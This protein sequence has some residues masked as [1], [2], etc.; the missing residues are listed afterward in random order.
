MVKLQFTWLGPPGI[1]LDGRP[2]RLEMRKTL[3][4]LAYLSLSP[5]PPTRESLSTLFWPE[6]DQKHALSNLRRNLSSLVASLPPN[7]LTID[8]DRLGLL[9]NNGLN[10]DV[11]Q[12]RNLLAQR[13]QHGHPP[14]EICTQCVP[15]LEKAFEIYR[16]DFFEG[17]NLKDCPEF[18][19]WQ[20][21]TRE[22]L[23]EDF[24]EVLERLSLYY[25]NNGTWDKAISYTR[26]RLTLDRLNEPAQRM[27]IEQY[28]LSGQKN[29]ALR[30]F[31]EYKQFLDQELGQTPEPELLKLVEEIKKAEPPPTKRD[32][33]PLAMR[34]SAGV[35][36]MTLTMT[37][38]YQPKVPRTIFHRQRLVDQLNKSIDLP[39]TL[40]SA[41]AGFGKTTLL[42]EWIS[43]SKKSIAWISLDSGDN[44]QSLLLSYIVNAIRNTYPGTQIGSMAVNLLASSQPV[45]SAMILG[46]LINDLSSIDDQLVLV[47]DDYHNIESPAAHEVFNFLIDHLPENVHLVIST[48]SD[49]PL[50]LARLKANLQLGIIRTDDLRF[51]KEE[52]REFLTHIFGFQI[53]EFDLDFFE[54][55]VEGWIAG[56]QLALL[57]MR[58]GNP[59]EL[60]EFIGAFKGG[61]RDILDYLMQEVLDR[62]PE[63]IRRF[64]LHTSILEKLTCSLCECLRGEDQSEEHSSAD[65]VA[66]A[67]WKSCQQILEYLER[68]NI[69]LIPLDDE[70]KWFRYHH[71][72][73][74][75]LHL[76]LKQYEP[77]QDAILHKRAADWYAKNSYTL[78]AI[79][80][81]LDSGDFSYAADLIEEYS[82]KLIWL[83]KI[84]ITLDWFKRLPL[85]V[86]ESHPLLSIYQGF[87][88]ARQ[89]EF[90][91]VDSI[92][93]NIEHY[94]APLPDSPKI[95]EYRI[96]SLGMRAFIANLRGEPEKSIQIFEDITPLIQ[97]K[98]AASYFVTRAQ[99]AVAYLDNGNL[100]SAEL[101][102]SEMVERAKENQDI[103]FTI[104]TNKE[105]AE[106]YNIQ[107][108]PGRA[109]Q[110]Y[111]QMYEWLQQNIHDPNLYSG[112]LKVYQARQLIEKNELETASLLL[113]EEMETML[114]VWQSSALYMGYV[115]LSDFLTC[116][117]DYKR[118]DEMIKKALQHVG[119][120]SM[121]PRNRS[122]VQASQVNLWLAEDNLEEA[123]NWALSTFPQMPTEFPFLKESDHICLARIW[124]KGQQWEDAL[125]LL[126]HL[127][128]A[129]E[130][131]KRFGRLLK[132]NILQS[133]ALHALGRSS[134]A[135]D[136]LENCIQFASREN[137]M[138]V[139]L[140]EGNPMRILLLEAKENRGWQDAELIKYTD[141]ILGA[142]QNRTS[143]PALSD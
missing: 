99:L 111:R 48:R 45:K 40:I 117:G 15:L 108:C 130:T 18:D 91:R 70:R 81:A 121:Y 135:L 112:L 138:K 36:D 72:F 13:T 38:F 22:N 5:Q 93:E 118:A 9:K 126:Q 64:L 107:G 34:S 110:M 87:I 101:V 31:D 134:E 143:S 80:H 106:I 49:P 129:A 82:L 141:K 55:K 69:F 51:T 62:Q 113:N 10:V 119:S 17:F 86:I 58:S 68:N 114:G 57:A 23:R 96:L 27:L 21:F 90:S 133:L 92:L 41:S 94:L 16:G 8:R 100:S 29:A 125:D 88:L 33:L 30:Q 59:S 131:G 11:I 98:H 105:I 137:Y 122:T 1:E 43:Q 104:L 24:E 19:D 95:V 56:I 66:S 103:Y 54:N 128:K 75:L 102:F 73:A 97:D 85:G 53:S 25:Q 50:F 14:H 7:L 67:E 78:E 74:E 3:A 47:L 63:E 132:I 120:Q 127:S 39:L 20:F 115:A 142:F 123:Q 6:F 116:A 46:T 2:L 79:D 4:L 77:H 35:N 136:M 28:F 124:I 140:D 26:F 71:L 84:V 139:F 37:K 42:A 61:Q 76:R 60:N 12:F 52:M 83:N 89:G 65:G 44:D 32:E 109:E